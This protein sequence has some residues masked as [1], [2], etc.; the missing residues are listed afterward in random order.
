MNKKKK[1]SYKNSTLKEYQNVL[2]REESKFELF[3]CEKKD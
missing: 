2:V 3:A 1:K